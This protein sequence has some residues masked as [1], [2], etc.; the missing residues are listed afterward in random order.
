MQKPDMSTD[1]DSKGYQKELQ[2]KNRKK[3]LNEQR[4]KQ[5]QHSK[6][7]FN[8][9]KNFHAQ[10]N[11]QLQ[12]DIRAQRQQENIKNKKLR[13]VNNK[14]SKNNDQSLF[15]KPDDDVY[16]AMAN[17]G[18]L[19]TNTSPERADKRKAEKE[20]QNNK[21]IEKQN[22]QRSGR[23]KRSIRG[24]S[25]IIRKYDNNKTV[26]RLNKMASGNLLNVYTHRLVHWISGGW[27]KQN[28]L[29]KKLPLNTFYNSSNKIYTKNSVKMPIALYSFPDELP[30][31]WFDECRDYLER[32]R[33]RFNRENNSNLQV[34]LNRT[35]KAD[36]S[37]FSFANNKRYHND[38]D[39][40]VKQ[41]EENARIMNDEKLNE[42]E[43]KKALGEETF[44]K[45][46]TYEW[47]R[48]IEDQDADSFWSTWEFLEIVV[49]GGE[50]TVTAELLR[51]CY[52]TLA[53]RL[54]ILEIKFK[55]LYETVQD[56]YDGYSPVG[57]GEQRKNFL[58]KKY[59][60]QLRS[61]EQIVAPTMLRQG[62]I[63]DKSGVPVGI[64][65][66]GES[67]LYID[68]SDN[69]LPPST[70]ITATSGHGKTYFIQS[71]LTGFLLFPD[72]YFPVI[73]DWKNEYVKLGQ[74]ANMQVISSSPTDGLYFSTIEIPAATGNHDIDEH[75]K[76]NALR[77]TENIFEI[78]LGPLWNEK[79]VK[80][81]FEYIRS[82][83]YRKH[84]VYLDDP[85]TWKYSEGLNFHTFY[86]EIDRIRREERGQ[87]FE[88]VNGTNIN[89]NAER[90]YQEIQE[91]LAPYFEKNGSRSSFFKKAIHMD[92]IKKSNGLI[93]AL[94][95]DQ[96]KG[97]TDEDTRLQLSMQF[98]LHIINNLT[99][100]PQNKKR[101]ITIFYEESNRLLQL[102]KV[103]DI[104]AGFASSGRSR[105]IRNF[106]ITN[107]PGQIFDLGNDKR[108]DN[109][110]AETKADPSSIKS[111]LENIGSVIIG[112]NNTNDMFQ[113][114]KYFNFNTANQ[115][116]LLELLA[117]E[118]SQASDDSSIMKHKF[119]IK[120]RGK[121][122]LIEAIS[123]KVI[124][125]MNIFGTSTYVGAHELDKDKLM[126]ELINDDTHSN[127]FEKKKKIQQH[128]KESLFGNPH[129][130]QSNINNSP[131]VTDSNNY[132]NQN[133][134]NN[135]SNSNYN[136]SQNYNN[137][138]YNY[139]NQQNYNNQN[140]NYN[141]QQNLQNNNNSNSLF[142]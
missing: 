37:N 2:R 129:S 27:G 12:E 30:I 115:I 98:I 34:A 106:F 19:K 18:S 101:L 38:Y 73:I 111:I 50:S 24:S 47:A 114:A 140:H 93:F 62:S 124:D 138:N 135:Y 139:N 84:G 71:L 104:M 92:D 40:L 42:R 14:N 125:D 64:D 126:N 136:G 49:S 59:A 67:P 33:N 90:I 52:E 45:L 141:N 99:N 86:A 5:L 81:A 142:H 80:T 96:E 79:G 28:L 116:A 131:S 102:P 94:D 130:Q 20:Y 13:S 68:Y 44:R 117:D 25:E 32:V 26:N 6:S 39:W 77:T 113:L 53:N 54:N 120:H 3:Q 63:S 57:H 112:A 21:R 133:M 29:N 1:F 15:A 128:A 78:L 137:Q 9:S 121:T 76:E 23:I 88:A 7:L 100:V 10:H 11:K 46:R 107:A 122:T 22:N 56:Y 60:P 127:E 72:L 75:N 31:G 110:Y 61:G 132:N 105:G 36:N 55:D 109:K 66:Y 134:T 108:T 91:A 69:S 41:Y 119:I 103:A 83:L 43:K 95:R 87:A 89:G 85:D 17:F 4:E 123:H 48:Q 70:L 8:Q 16:D 118:Q 35:I 58:F 65:I 82:S 74:T 51:E 97:G